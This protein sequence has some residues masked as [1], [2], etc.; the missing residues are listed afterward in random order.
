L[1][2]C[3]RLPNALHLLAALGALCVLAISP[4]AANRS[5]LGMPLAKI[6]CPAT[7]HP[8]S[9]GRHRVTYEGC[10]KPRGTA[11]FLRYGL[12]CAEIGH[13]SAISASRLRSDFWCLVFDGA[14]NCSTSGPQ[15]ARGLRAIQGTRGSI[16]LRKMACRSA[17]GHEVQAVQGHQLALKG[18]APAVP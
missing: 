13:G 18:A 15:N 9:S 2:Q 8:P 16:S 1:P 3:T 12:V 4:V 11:R 7:G 14:L 10:S 6:F 5:P 17:A